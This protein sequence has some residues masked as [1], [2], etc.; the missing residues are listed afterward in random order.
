MG[1][2]RDDRAQ[3]AERAGLS[4][5][6]GEVA[7]LADELLF[8]NALDVDAQDQIPP[9]HFDALAAAGLY[10]IAG[11]RDA[12]GL[13][14]DVVT[15]RRVREVLAGG[16]LTTAFVWAQ[17]HGA[18]RCVRAAPAAIRDAWLAPLC[19]GRSRAGLALSGLLPGPVALRIARR[20]SG[21]TVHGTSPMVTG[22]GYIDV[23]LVAARLEENA[24][25]F[26]LV[27]TAR[28]GLRARRRRLAAL[29]AA[30]TVR[31][32]FD[33][34][35]LGAADVVETVALPR[36]AAEGESVRSNGVLAIGVAERCARLS[37]S[38][39]LRA[40]VAAARDA[41]DAAADGDELAQARADAALLAMRAAS[42]LVAER[43]STAIDLQDHAQRLAREAI[44]LLAFGQRPAIKQALLR[45]LE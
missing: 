37:S 10:G 35:A 22:W 44:F 27:D 17:H 20:G 32:D 18:V 25:A 38:A 28:P 30:R 7:R 45:G 1:L 34:V 33:G 16:C 6:E 26:A 5:L 41:L 11:P 19:D 29:D 36:W 23:I 12:G 4:D 9:G 24:I 21:W 42:R 8:A 13:D 39:P 2:P 40:E 14:L 15:Q 43:G 31:L 3:H